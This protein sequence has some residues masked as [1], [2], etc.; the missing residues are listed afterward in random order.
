MN[1]VLVLALLGAISFS[2]SAW[3]QPRYA[4]W[5]SR[6]AREQD[7]IQVVLGDSRR[8]FANHFFVKADVYLH[9]GFYPSVFDTPAAAQH[10]HLAEPPEHDDHDD[11]DGGGAR[12]AGAVGGSSSGSSRHGVTEADV[13]FLGA[14]RDWIDNFSRHFFPSRHV[15]LRAG[16]EEQEVLPW[17][18]FA[19]SVDPHHVYAYTTGGYWLWRHAKRPDL[20]AQFLREGWTA[21]PDSYEIL[22]HLGNL[23]SSEWHDDARACN[24]W[25]LAWHNWQAQELGQSEPDRFGGEQIL[26]HL[27]DLEVRQEHFVE[28]LRYL[29]RLKTF[30]PSAEAIQH[31]IDEL[32]S[33]SS[34]P[35]PAR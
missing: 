5:S 18:R 19:V 4:A 8:L 35:A 11:H 21:N 3:L 28:A 10:L 6:G 16:A 27:A 34:P 31:Q 33:R 15:H 2:L 22:L 14:P 17:L 24:L 29:E 25:E 7:L 32:R 23:Y 30:S 20:A 9:A 26:A 1:P 12:V 13:G